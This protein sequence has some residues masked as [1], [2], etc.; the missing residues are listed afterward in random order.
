L[1]ISENSIVR[2]SIVTDSKS[3]LKDSIVTV[4]LDKD[5]HVKTVTILK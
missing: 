2:E 4:N 1:K 5:G 3:L